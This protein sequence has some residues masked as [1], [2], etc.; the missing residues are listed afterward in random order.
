MLNARQAVVLVLALLAGP[1]PPAYAQDAYPNQ[2]VRVI[3][4]FPAGGTTDIV[5]RLVAQRMTES[6]GR[7]V[8]V[9]NRAGAGGT[10]GAAAVAKA[11]ADGY[12]LLLHNNAFVTA[13]TILALA[14]RLPYNLEK[15]FV[16]IS[17]LVSVP[18][19]LAVHPGV[20]A[21]DLKEL[22]QWLKK[23]PDKSYGSTGPGSLANLWAEVYKS[24]AGVDIQHVPFK[25]A[26]PAMQ[27][28]VA[29][30]I[31]VL[32]D[33]MPTALTQVRAAKVRVVVVT[34]PQRSASLP[35]VTTAREQGY[36]QLEVLIWNS[37][38]APAG[39]PAAI[40]QRIQAEA[41]K[42]IRHPAVVARLQDL[43]ADAVGSTPEEFNQI[44]RGQIAHWTPVIKKLGITPD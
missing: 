2:P 38:F 7:Q 14:N 29:G 22:A 25:G 21:K 39:T 33:Q 23:N 37:L 5:A 35:E 20:P 19:V 43:S 44:F 27:E 24:L 36:P 18:G 28:L 6:M 41:A 13:S 3:V 1:F 9:D 34:T 12:T 26:A 11:P 15:D 40:T 17:M 31:V 42:A 8:I 32:F 4:P 16:P 30:R 10:I